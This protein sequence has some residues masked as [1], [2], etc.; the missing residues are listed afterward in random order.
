MSDTFEFEDDEDQDLEERPD[1]SSVIKDLR[2]QAKDGRRAAR[3]RDSLKA[4]NLSL[5]NERLIRQAGLDKLNERQQKAVLREIEGEATAESVKE[6]ALDLG[7]IQAE[8]ENHDE[9]DA[10]EQMANAAA[11]GNTGRTSSDTLTAADFAKWDMP[12][13]KDF[14]DRYPEKFAAL[15][16]NENV[17]L[18]G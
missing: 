5:K 8:D 14:I 18:S 13:K 9:D 4:E 11:N 12:R 16:R 1:D 3:E 15:K 7:F 17:K 6:I 10:Q 2:K